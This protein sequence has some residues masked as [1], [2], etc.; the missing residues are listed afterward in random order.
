MKTKKVWTK[1]ENQ[2]LVKKR[3][4]QIVDAVLELFSDKGFHKT[5]MRDISEASGIE[6]SYLYKYISSKDDILYLFHQHL[7]EQWEE[8][9]QEPYILNIEN[10]RDQLSELLGR[11]LDIIHRSRRVSLA[12]LTETRHL[13]KDSM[14]A[15]LGREAEVVKTVEK[16]I[17]RGVDEGCFKTDDPIISANIIHHMFVFEPM[18]DWNL[19]GRYTFEEYRDRIISQTM[20]I[21]DAGI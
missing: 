17:R 3:H 12:M 16:I 9:V 21:L 15:I 4:Q 14:R 10:P 7:I 19:R 2:E 11:M 5:S 18:R 6:L 1:V 20:K 13:Q 8:V